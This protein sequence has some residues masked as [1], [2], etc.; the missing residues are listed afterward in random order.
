MIGLDTL[1]TEWLSFVLA[2]FHLKISFSKKMM[3]SH[4]TPLHPLPYHISVI[5]WLYDNLHPSR[6]EN[7]S[8]AKEEVKTFIC[9][10]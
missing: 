1:K 10:P 6:F 9:L 2:S 5:V 3:N 8:I 4:L 7:D